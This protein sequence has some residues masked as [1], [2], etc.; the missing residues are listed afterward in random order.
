MTLFRSQL[1][2]LKFTASLIEGGWESVN[3]CIAH[4]ALI[5]RS[6]NVQGIEEYK[7]PKILMLTPYNR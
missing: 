3:L 5:V 6:C 7:L 4:I 2:M 1:P